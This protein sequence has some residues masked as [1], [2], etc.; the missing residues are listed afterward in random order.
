MSLT[1]GPSL[2]QRSSFNSIINVFRMTREEKKRAEALR[3]KAN[4]L[5]AEMTQMHM[6][7]PDDL[8]E[9]CGTQDGQLK[10]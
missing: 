1:A 3:R 4:E 2:R 5:G 8:K 7:L 10:L 6:L 9:V